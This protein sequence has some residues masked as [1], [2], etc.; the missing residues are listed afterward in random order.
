MVKIMA[1][2]VA[3]IGRRIDKNFDY[4]C[5]H[6]KTLDSYSQRLNEAERRLVELQKLVLTK[7][8]KPT[9]R[10]PELKKLTKPEIEKR[11][12]RSEKALTE[13]KEIMKEFP[14]DKPR[15]PLVKTGDTVR[16]KEGARHT[17][18]EGLQ[19][20]VIHVATGSE[21]NTYPVRIRYEDG[22]TEL[23]KHDDLEVI[24]KFAPGTLWHSEWTGFDYRV[25]ADG[26]LEYWSVWKS[27]WCP[28]QHSICDA[29]RFIP[30]KR[31][32]F[33]E[34]PASRFKRGD[35]IVALRDSRGQGYRGNTGVIL[36]VVWSKKKSIYLLKT[37]QDVFY[38]PDCGLAPAGEFKGKGRVRVV[39]CNSEYGWWRKHIGKEFDVGGSECSGDK[40]FYKLSG[41]VR[42][43]IPIADCELLPAHEPCPE[44][45]REKKEVQYLDEK[46]RKD[47]PM[48][49]DEVTWCTPEEGRA[50]WLIYIRDEGNVPADQLEPYEPFAVGEFVRVSGDDCVFNNVVVKVIQYYAKPVACKE[51]LVEFWGGGTQL[52]ATSD[53]IAYEPREGERVVVKLR[54]GEMLHGTYLE[55]YA[56]DT[57]CH[58]V[59]C[60]ECGIEHDVYDDDIESITPDWSGE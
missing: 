21:Y 25:I 16:V 5:K 17:L 41:A 38:E 43:F 33:D 59:K 31:Q 45:C 49:V 23:F 20:K 24:P 37:G 44:W 7:Q 36:D 34:P 22:E 58:L 60:A 2:Q 13:L 19:G 14:D 57:P 6:K 18:R 28:S 32:D 4:L 51:W 12:K 42:G 54:D 55:R 48:I 40:R 50:Y 27:C 1:K 3:K 46:I 8:P 52:Y 53:L 9:H 15:E 29:L 47:E 39:R 26:K 56:D 35:T 30:R 11:L 10:E